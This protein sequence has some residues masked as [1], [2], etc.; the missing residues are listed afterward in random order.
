MKRSIGL[1]F[2][3]FMTA[4]MLCAQTI[5]VTE[6]AA[7]ETWHTG[8]TYLITW[9]KSGTM[10]ATVRIALRNAAGTSEV[11]TI[12]DPAPNTGSYSWTIPKDI[13]DGSYK[14]R[15][16]AKGT[17][18]EGDS[19]TFTISSGPIQ[20][21]LRSSEISKG[22]V[23]FKFPAL[24]IYQASM[25]AYPDAFEVN[26]GYKNSGTGDLPK[27]SDMPVKPTFRVLVDNR[28]VNQGNLVIPA[29]PAPPGWVMPTF[30]A[31]EIKRQTSGSF[32]PT[33]FEGN[34]LTI[35]INENK[36][37]GMA[38]DTQTYSLRNMALLYGYDIGINDV[39]L[40]WNTGLLTVLVRLEGVFKA[41]DEIHIE[42]RNIYHFPG[43]D[44]WH[45]TAKAVPGQTLYTLSRKR[46]GLKG[47]N[48]HTVALIVW[49][50]RP[51]DPGLVL[52][53]ID[54]RN[55]QYDRVFHR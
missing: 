7:G 46:D 11:R 15:V 28:Q 51:S 29:F 40:D 18:I 49:L 25:V 35:Y 39:T 16:K 34:Q 5:T 13:P 3:V 42:D 48:D 1:V 9:T 21:P 54:H 27:N 53:D 37:N 23:A 20:V 2:L 55:N 24:S 52:E 8:L 30:F 14:I 4:G 47:T 19:V 33:V 43:Y 6:P 44:W 26:F 45:I 12:Q 10:P 32:D 17:N 38:S 22:I 36:V 31:C 41:N 50:E